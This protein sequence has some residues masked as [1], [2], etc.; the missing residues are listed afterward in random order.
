MRPTII[1]AISIILSLV[2]S[3]SF[4][5]MTYGSTLAVFGLA[6]VA[7]ELRFID[8]RFGER[9][10]RRFSFTLAVLLGGITITRCSMVFGFA[11]ASLAYNFELVLVFL[12]AFSTLMQ[13]PGARISSLFVVILLSI[14]FLYSPISTILILAVLHNL[15]PMGFIVEIAPPSSKMLALMICVAIFLL[16]PLAIASGIFAALLEP[17][18]GIHQ[19]VSLLPTGALEQHLGVFLPKSLHTTTWATDA[20]SAIV[21]AQCMH[22]LAVTYVM[23]KLIKKLMPKETI[24]PF[25]PWPNTAIFWITIVGLTA[26]L[27]IFYLQDFI[28]AR[29]VY[30]IAAAMHAY[31]E[32]PILLLAFTFTKKFATNIPQSAPMPS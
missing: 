20:F 10:T 16:L 2:M 14:G 25:F 21:F 29:A 24:K 13:V 30:G 9:I 15:T 11:P 22:Y 6:H 31:L 4:P 7:N 19:N 17:M 27:A 5:L 18:I 28:W 12:L 8:Q 1:I 3:I 26:I 32:I 23:P